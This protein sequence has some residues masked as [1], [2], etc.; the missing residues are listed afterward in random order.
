MYLAH[1]KV[2]PQYIGKDYYLIE[3]NYTKVRLNSHYYKNN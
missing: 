3:L 2:K 1:A